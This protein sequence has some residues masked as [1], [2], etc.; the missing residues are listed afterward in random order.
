MYLLKGMYSLRCTESMSIG[1]SSVFNGELETE[2]G[3]PQCQGISHEL[4]LGKPRHAFLTESNLQPSDSVRQLL[5]LHQSFG[6]LETELRSN[7]STHVIDNS[8]RFYQF[9]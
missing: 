6:E 9:I 7:S 1:V 5:P 8:N 3:R 4:G 2:K